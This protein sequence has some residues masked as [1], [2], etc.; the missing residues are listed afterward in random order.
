MQLNGTAGARL[1][2]DRGRSRAW[3]ARRI[4]AKRWRR[5]ERVMG[6]S[7]S[8]RRSVR[9]AGISVSLTSWKP[10][11]QMLPLVLLGLLEQTLRPTSIDVWLTPEDEFCFDKAAKL[12]FQR[13]GVR[14]Q[15][16]ANLGPHKKWLPL[17]ET[18]ATGAFA[19]CDDDILYPPNW[20]ER[21]VAEDRPDAYVGMRCHRMRWSPDGVLLPYGD[22]EKDVGPNES[23]AS[24]LFITGCG[25]AIIHPERLSNRFLDRDRI[26][27]ECPMADDIWLK[28]AHE[29]SGF[30]CH[31]TSFSF[32]CLEL[33][34]SQASG[35]VG[36]NVGHG[37][38]DLQM[39]VLNQLMSQRA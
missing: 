11:L 29:A 39:G 20:L 25:G 37:H 17:V 3:L 2:R 38:N 22:W 6:E 34:D 4:A 1:L 15:S 23:P 27:A 31:K 28:A 33:P 19:I 21:L 14:F 26:A 36:L 12:L 32:P 18:G 16:C 9:S 13:H 35:L 24:D 10:R 7:V 30:P 5:W 8:V